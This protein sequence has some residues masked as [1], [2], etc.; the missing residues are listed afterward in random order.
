ARQAGVNAAVYAKRIARSLHVTLDGK[1]VGLVPVAR[2]LAF[3]RGLG[4]LHT[5]RLE[6]IL[7]GPTVQRS[8]RLRVRDTNYGDR[9]GWRELVVGARTPSVSDELRAYP[10]SL[11]QSPLDVTTANAVVAPTTDP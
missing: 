4:G 1:R 11:L 7:R 3:P 2:A 10:K 8:S 6:T 9:I 5:L